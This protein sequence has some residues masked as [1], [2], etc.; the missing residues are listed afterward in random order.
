MDL[1]LGLAINAMH[2][3]V[4]FAGTGIAIQAYG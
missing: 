4:F 3:L 2:D 1:W